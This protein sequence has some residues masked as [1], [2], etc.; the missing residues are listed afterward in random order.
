MKTPQLDD[1]ELKDAVSATAKINNYIGIMQDITQNIR[2]NGFDVISLQTILNKHKIG[3]IE[4]IKDKSLFFIIDYIKIILNDHTITDKERNNISLLKRYFKIEEGD[5]YKHKYSEIVEILNRQFEKIYEDGI[6]TNEEDIHK[7]EVQD[8]FDLSYDQFLEIKEKYISKHR[9][10]LKQLEL[11][12]QEI[13]EKLLEKERKKQLHR[14]A[15][16]ELIEEGKVF[17]KRKIGEKNREPIP[18]EVMNQVWN[19]GGGKC[20]KCGSL[21]NLEFDHIIPFSKGGANTYRNL[22]LLCQ[23]CN[24]QKSDNI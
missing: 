15:L 14:Q 22:Q 23:K 13:K 20:V 18:K 3:K 5:L 10:K 8:L 24:R 4:Y 7:F 17:N 6:I 9:E 19:R 21:E 16:E 1:L 2:A 11:K 12:K